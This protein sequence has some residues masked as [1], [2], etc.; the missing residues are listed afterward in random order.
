MSDDA[1]LNKEFCV[2]LIQYVVGRANQN[3]VDNVALYA[4]CAGQDQ[5]RRHDYTNTGIDPRLEKPDE[6][7]MG[8]F[9]DGH[10]LSRGSSV[11]FIVSTWNKKFKQMFK[12]IDLILTIIQMKS[13]SI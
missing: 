11:L 9:R 1:F 13:G 3:F 8:V 2:L 7:M 12:E 6:Y 5:V 4:G 10:L